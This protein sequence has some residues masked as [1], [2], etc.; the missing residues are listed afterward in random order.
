MCAFLYLPETQAGVGLEVG[1]AVGCAVGLEVGTASYPTTYPTVGDAVG[2]SDGYDVGDSVGAAVGLAAGL[3]VGEAV[4][5]ITATGALAFAETTTDTPA[6]LRLLLIDALN[7][8]GGVALTLAATA[9]AFSGDVLMTVVNFT[10]TDTWIPTRSTCL[11]C[12]PY[13][14][15]KV[16]LTASC[17]AL[18]N[19]ARV[20]PVREISNV[21]TAVKLASSLPVGAA[22][23]D[24]VGYAVGYIVGADVG[25]AMQRTWPTLPAVHVGTHSLINEA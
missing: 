17:A 9:A 13:K 10:P 4:G 21:T 23:E 5:A 18:S 11:A 19:V 8:A 12:T 1:D 16:R 22:E 15:A 2:C 6:A 20:K 7:A 24:G 14:L 25:T 3:V